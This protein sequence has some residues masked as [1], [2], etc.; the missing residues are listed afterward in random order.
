MQSSVRKWGSFIDE[1]ARTTLF[2]KE[3]VRDVHSWSL[4]SMKRFLLMPIFFFFPYRVPDK[5]F[6]DRSHSNSNELL[7]LLRKHLRLILPP[8]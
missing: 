1:Q 5:Q 8:V 3:A 2:I 4:L 6:T 7:D